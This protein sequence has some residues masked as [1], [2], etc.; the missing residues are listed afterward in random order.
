MRYKLCGLFLGAFL[1]VFVPVIY[2][3]TQDVGGGL[4]YDTSSGRYCTNSSG[5]DYS[6]PTDIDQARADLAAQKEAVAQ[7]A[8]KRA[9]ENALKAGLTI[10]A[11]P[12]DKCLAGTKIPSARQCTA[13]INGAYVPI[14]YCIGDETVGPC[15]GE[16]VNPAV[17]A[18]SAIEQST[19]TG[20]NCVAQMVGFPGVD[21]NTG[22]GYYYNIDCG[23]MSTRAGGNVSP[24]VSTSGTPK[25][26]SGQNTGGVN[27]V[28][29]TGSTGGAGSTSAYVN[30]LLNVIRSMTATSKIAIS[31]TT[32]QVTAGTASN[33]AF[34]ASITPNSRILQI[35]S[36]ANVL[37]YNSLTSNEKIDLTNYLAVNRTA[38]IDQNFQTF[39]PGSVFAWALSMGTNT[40]LNA[41][42]LSLGF[43]NLNPVAMLFVKTPGATIPAN[44]AGTGSNCL[45]FASGWTGCIPSTGGAPTAPNTITFPM[46][47][48]VNIP[49]LNIR[50]EP[51]TTSRIINSFQNRAI[52]T[53]GNLVDGENID[54]NNKWLSFV[55]GT[56]PAYVWSGGTAQSPITP[57][58]INF[59]VTVTVI[60]TLPLN[61][62][63][64]P[65]TDAVPVT[66]LKGGDT[67]SASG[68]MDG[69][70]VEG[71]NQWWVFLRGSAPVYVWSGGAS[72]V[73]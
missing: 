13:V 14:T 56:M 47:V 24:S 64:A 37:L 23:D 58:A 41:Q 19:R 12:Q 28:G 34:P 52:F 57:A 29:G 53:A 11:P 21:P 42:A 73:H 4:Y 15:R 10:T 5:C 51:N 48:T 43:T 60:S 59:P 66:Q 61:V 35:I 55:Y 26:S 71:N 50:T 8:I 32:G 62:R 17:A 36:Q 16:R 2:G 6:N 38:L 40:T 20:K 46:A 65:R 3:A 67:F 7:E 44:T 45:T 68:I 27:N 33:T 30:S 18:I 72:V 70:N 54:G 25:F 49:I 69:E 39:A 1:F 22:L 9:V 31:N 63:N